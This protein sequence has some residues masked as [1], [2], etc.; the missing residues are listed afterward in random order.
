MEALKL[1]L[2]REG[3]VRFEVTARPR[4]RAARIAAVRAGSLVVEIVAPPADGAAN[5]ELVATLATSLS[6]AKRN[7]VLVRGQT[8]RVKLVEVHGIGLDEVRA[9]LERAM[10]RPLRAR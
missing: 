9:R 6:L 2:T 3:A 10:L 1:G 8:S 4:S 5:S 7:V